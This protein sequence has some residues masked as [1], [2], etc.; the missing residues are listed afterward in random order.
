MKSDTGIPQDEVIPD[1]QEEINPSEVIPDA[2]ASAIPPDEVIP[3]KIDQDKVIPSTPLDKY[4]TPIQKGATAV[5][6]A[7]SGASFGLSDLA[8]TK[9]GIATPEEIKN[10]QNANPEVAV[11]SNIVGTLASMLVP[12]VG[13]GWVLTKAGKLLFPIA[14]EAN[15]MAKV[16]RLA[17]R[18]AIEGAGMASGNELS[19][20]FL[21]KG[22]SAPAVVGHIV[23]SGALGMLTA[24]T[25]GAGKVGLEEMQNA[26][27]GEYIDNFAIGLGK[28]S[29][30]ISLPPGITPV[31]KQLPKAIEHGEKFYKGLQDIIT[32]RIVDVPST[33]IAGATAAGAAKLATPVGLSGPA[34]L[35]GLRAGYKLAEKYVDPASEKLASKIAP[36]IAKKVAVPILLKAIQTGETTGLTQVLNYGTK[37]AKGANLVAEAMDSL[38][39][40]GSAGAMNYGINEL[41]REKLDQYIQNGGIN[42]Q[43]DQ[44][45]NEEPVGIAKRSQYAEGGEVKANPINSDTGLAKMY[46]DQHLMLTTAKGRVANYLTSIRP[47]PPVGFMFDDHYKDP[48]KKKNYESALDIAQQPLRVLQ[49]IQNGT[50]QPSD[51]AHLKA[52]YPEVSD[53]LA[54]K[55]TNR[56][57]QMQYEKK[58]P[59]YKLL[60]GLS[61]FLGAP[62]DGTF[63]QPYIQAAQMTYIPQTNMRQQA[64]PKKNT[65]KLG[66]SDKLHRT[67]SQMAEAD[68]S[69][70]KIT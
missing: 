13:E 20:A 22:H 50:I 37:A 31:E 9:L 55:I 64:P 35:V 56:L 54:N 26:K 25:T 65:D 10:R 36:V 16:G 63:S 18:G 17:L 52:M 69:A 28:A 6:S 42:Q 59:P 15:A 46:P 8:E 29:S 2:Q 45:R 68:R 19:D 14:K 53:H 12:G 3:D 40:T 27:L 7:L 41:D 5:E 30:G 48:V 51:I 21:D 62:L 1:S 70:R 23:G 4:K 60:Q 33:A 24:G 58:K 61:M 38:F 47:Q 32:R 34:G 39:K 67:T 49:S 57:T 66:K 44:I 43:I 11:G